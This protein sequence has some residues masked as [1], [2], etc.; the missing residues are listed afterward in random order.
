MGFETL[1]LAKPLLKVLE[2]QGLVDPTPIQETSIPIILRGRDLV[3]L[4]QTGTGKTAAF[5][6]PV[7]TS[8]YGAERRGKFRPV[9]M[10]VLSP[11]RE[12]AAQ[13]EG[14]IKEL[15]S[16]VNL[17]SVPIFGGVPFFRQA[18]ALRRGSDILVATP[19]RLEDHISQKTLD[20]SRVTHV[21]LDEADQMLDI[22]FLPAIKRIFSLLP[23]NKQTLLFSATMPKEIKKLSNDY[24]NN[25]DEVAVTPES[26]PAEKVIQQ[27][28]FLTNSEKLNALQDLLT[29]RQK[30]RILVFS[31]TKHGADKVVKTL[32]NAGLSL[33]AIHGNK[34]QTQ[35]QLALENFK[36]GKCFV[37][38]ATDIAARGID[39]RGVE[40]VVNYD[41]PD[42][43]E[44]YVHRIG[45]TA[46]AGASGQAISFC[47]DEE[48]KNLRA[49]EKL[50]KMEIQNVSLDWKEIV[51]PSAVAGRTLKK[52]IKRRMGK[53]EVMA[54]SG[55]VKKAMS[56]KNS[57][58]RNRLV[59]RKKYS[60][61]K[62][63]K[64]NRT[65]R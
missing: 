47:T 32:T 17:K 10:L 4:A 53:N 25:P 30:K 16:S 50:I 60:N 54:S 64:N 34:S 62:G 65:N 27:V 2:R 21:I 20:L 41:L 23:K 57:T 13:V 12:L 63:A 58:Q 37:L 3:G 24:L 36:R 46:R 56:E 35:R 31:R 28:V 55:R 44:T 43:P 61:S 33:N 7:L 14:V 5:S 38:I 15:S 59:R 8:L 22:G 45:R 42:V 18:Q 29:R 19:G 6:L 9:R 11:T 40:L 51:R 49:I 48:H 26:R 52:S 1:G 39:V